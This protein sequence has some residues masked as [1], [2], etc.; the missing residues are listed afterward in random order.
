MAGKIDKQLKSQ[1]HKHTFSKGRLECS[2]K[3][4]PF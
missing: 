3:T 4:R 1:D 2:E